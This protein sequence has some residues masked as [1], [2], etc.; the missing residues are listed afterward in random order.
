MK[1]WNDY[2]E[3]MDP[4]NKK[5]RENKA[6][7]VTRA[8]SVKYFSVYPRKAISEQQAA[9]GRVT[10]ARQTM[11]AQKSN[12][13]KSTAET[14]FQGERYTRRQTEFGTTSNRPDG[15]HINFAWVD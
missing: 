4:G 12:A 3:S 8:A 6:I 7:D 11:Q 14:S 13:N 1:K 15:G 9:S 2:Y 10:P 5:P